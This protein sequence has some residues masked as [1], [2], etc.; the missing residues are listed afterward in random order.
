MTITD[1]GADNTVVDVTG[2]ALTIRNSTGIGQSAADS[3]NLSVDTLNVTTT[4]GNAFITEANGIALGVVNVMA[5]SLTFEAILGDITDTTGD[6]TAGALSL[7]ATESGKAIGTTGTPITVDA[8]G[9]L[10]A[11][12]TTSTGGI[13]IAEQSGSLA[14][15]TV[16]AGT[17]DI[18]LSAPSGFTN[19]TSALTG[20]N[21]KL[22]ASASGGS[23]GAT[24][25]ANDINVTLTGTLTAAASTGAGGIFITETNQ[26]D[27]ASLNAGSGA[28]ELITSAGDITDGGSGTVVTSGTFTANSAGAVTLD[29]TG[30]HNIATLGTSTSATTFTLDNN[31][32][33][34]T[35]AGNLT[36][37]NSAVTLNLGTGNYTHNTNIDINSGA[38]DITITTDSVVV[39]ANSGDNAFITS[40]TL[41]LN[42]ATTATAITLG[43]GNTAFDIEGTKSGEESFAIAGGVTGT[44]KIG[45]SDHNTTLTFDKNVSFGTA[46]V[47]LQA[48]SLVDGDGE[49]TAGTLYLDARNGSI[50]TS[51]NPMELDVTTLDATTTGGSAGGIFVLEADTLI[52]GNNF[53]VTTGAIDTDIEITT[54]KGNLTTATAVKTTGSGAAGAGTILLD[55]GGVLTIDDFVTTTGDGDIS[56]KSGATATIRTV[57]NVG[58]TVTANS[59]NVDGK[60]NL[61]VSVVNGDIQ[62]DTGKNDILLL[63]DETGANRRSRLISLN[64]Q[65]DNNKGD[66]IIQEESNDT[67]GSPADIQQIYGAGTSLTFPDGTTVA[68]GDDATLRRWDAIFTP[69]MNN[70]API[71]IVTDLKINTNALVGPVLITGDG[72]GGT[73][74]LGDV[75]FDMS[76]TFTGDQDLTISAVSI[77]SADNVVETHD[78]VTGLIHGVPI[79]LGATGASVDGV[80]SLGTL[81]LTTNGGIGT[82]T[83]SQ[84]TA[85]ELAIANMGTVVIPS[86]GGNDI[87]ISEESGTG[88]TIALNIG[89]KAV[90]VG[91]VTFSSTLRDLSITRINAGTNAVNLLASA[92]SI[93]DDADDV[94]AAG[95]EDIIGGTVTLTARDE[96]GGDDGTPAG[97]DGQEALEIASTSLNV[98]TT[99]TLATHQIVLR[100]TDGTTLTLLETFEDPITVISSSGDLIAADVH[101]GRTTPDSVTLTASTGAIQGTSGGAT[102][103]TGNAAILTAANGIGAT[104]TLTTAVSG[105][106]TFSNTVT[107]GINLSDS[108]GTSTTYAGTNSG[109]T[110][111]I[112]DSDKTGFTTGG[113]ITG[114]SGLLAIVADTVNI[115]HTINASTNNV[116]ISP[117]TLLTP[118]SLDGASTLDLEQAELTKITAGRIFIGEDVG[119]TIRA[120]VVTL[121]GTLDVDVG[122]QNLTIAGTA[123]NGGAKTLITTG[124]VTLNSSG[125]VNGNAAV[126]TDI[127]AGS[128]NITAVNGIGATQFQTDT[129]S[130]TA[131]NTSVTTGN[132]NISNAQS[133]NLTG[134]SVSNSNATGTIQ[135]DVTGATS[136]LTI[137][138]TVTGNSN[139]TLSADRHIIFAQGTGVTGISTP[140]ATVT[141][142]ANLDAALPSTTGAIQGNLNVATDVASAILF[143]NAA[144]GIGSTNAIETTATVGVGPINTNSGDVNVVNTGTVQMFGSNA[145]GG[146]YNFTVL[147][148]NNSLLVTSPVN[149]NTGTVTLT[150]DELSIGSTV[151]GT[152]VTL[153]AV[154]DLQPIEIGLT[155]KTDGTVLG[156]TDL[157][158]LNIKSSAGLT[159]GNATSDGGIT[160]VGA[161]TALKTDLTGG[162]LTLQQ[163]DANILV[164]ATLISPVDTTLI[165]ATSTKNGI[166]WGPAGQVSAAG[167]NVTLTAANR[168]IFGNGTAFTNVV[169][170]SLN[171]TASTGIGPTNALETAVAGKI[172]FSNTGSGNVQ[173]TD[174]GAAGTSYTGTNNNAPITLID[175]DATGIAVAAG[176]I[177]S[178]GN[179]VIT[180]R[181]NA[182]DIANLVNAGTSDV[183]LLPNSAIAGTIGGVGAFDLTQTELTTNITAGRIF[184]GKDSAGT[185]TGT[186]LSID[187]AVN[188]G[189]QELILTAGTDLTIKNTLSSTA[190]LTLEANNNIGFAQGVSVT[191]VSTTG[192]VNLTAD[193]DTSTAGAIT[194]NG[195]AATDVAADTLNASA[196]TGIGS[197]TPIETAVATL[198]LTNST[199]GAVR[200]DETDAVSVSGTN[201]NG[202][203]DVEVTGADQVLTVNGSNISAQSVIL[204][205]DQMTVTGTVT[206]TAG[207]TV[208]AENPT[209]QSIEIGVGAADSATVLGLLDTELMQFKGAGLTIG[210]GSHTQGITVV[211]AA[212]TSGLSSGTLTLQ[213]GSGNIAVNTTL[214][215]PIATTLTTASGGISFDPDGA[216]SAAGQTVTLTAT[217][218]SVTGDAATFTNVTAGT[219]NATAGGTI[220]T[221]TDALETAVSTVVASA[222]GANLNISNTGA[223]TATLTANSGDADFLNSGTF[224]TG[225][226]LSANSID[227]TGD[228]TVTIAHNMTTDGAANVGAITLTSTG[229]GTELQ[230]DPMT[231]ADIT[232]TTA[233]GNNLV[234]SSDKLFVDA[235]P[236]GS[237]GDG[238]VVFNISGGIPIDVGAAT[239]INLGDQ[240]PLG[241]F[242][243]DDAEM[244]A[245]VFAGSFAIGTGTTTVP[246][247]IDRATAFA[248]T[249]VTLT[250]TSTVNDADMGIALETSGTLTITASGAGTTNQLVTQ[251]GSLALFTGASDISD[252]GGLTL[253]DSTLT[254]QLDLTTVTG[255]LALDNLNADKQTVN[256]TLGGA[257][258][259]NNGNLNNLTAA[260]LN[261]LG[262][263]N[264]GSG[265]A[266]ETIVGTIGLTSAVTQIDNTNAAGLSVT[267]ST[268]T[269][270]LT[271]TNKSGDLTISN[272][273]SG[274]STITL[275]AD[276]HI[277]FAQPAATTGVTNVAG[278][279]ELTAD[280]DGNN[281][282]AVQGNANVATDV[283]AVFGLDVAAAEG[284]GD[285]NPLE[286][287][288]G[289][290][291]FTNTTSGDINLIDTNAGAVLGENRTAIAGSNTGG[292]DILFTKPVIEGRIWVFNAPGVA[293]GVDA[294][295][296]SVVLTADN[297]QIDADAFVEGNG[298][299]TLQPFDDTQAIQLGLGAINDNLNGA[300]GVNGFG[301]TNV[302]LANIKSS[303]G[304]VQIGNATSDGGITIVG[305]GSLSGLSATSSLKLQQD[306]GAITVNA[307]LTSP[308]A[309]TLTTANNSIGFGAAGAISAAGQSVTLSAAAGAITGDVANFTNV[310]GGSVTLTT[311]TGIGATNALQTASTG[312][313]AF[314]NSTSGV[315]QISDSGAAN[316]TFSGTNKSGVVNLADADATGLGIAAGGV[317]SGGANITLRANALDIANLVDATAA[318]V[319]LLPNTAS[320]AVAIGGAGT[321][322][323]LTQIELTTNTTAGRIFIGEDAAATVTAGIITLGSN[324]AVDV[325][326]QDLTISGASIVGG[327]NTLTSSGN[328]TLLSTGDIQG[329]AAATADVAGGTLTLTAATGLG[330][331]TQFQTSTTKLTADNTGA[332]ALNISNDQALNLDGGTTSSVTNT[333]TGPIQ[334]DVTGATNDLTI[335]QTVS[336]SSRI[337]LQADNNIVFAQATPITGV[338]TP[339]IVDLVADLDGKGTGAIQ[340]SAADALDVSASTLFA[341]AAQGIGTTATPLEATVIGLAFRNTTSGDV[342]LNP[343]DQASPPAIFG[344]NAGGGNIV[345]VYDNADTNVQ[346]FP[347]SAVATPWGLGN[348]GLNANTGSVTL[349]VDQ[350]RIDAPIAGAGVTIQPFEDLQAVE[351]GPLAVDGAA[352]LGIT[353]LEL[354]RISSSA[355]LTIGNAT[356][357]AG[358]TI[359]TGV[360]DAKGLTGGTFTL[361]QDTGSIIVNGTL[362]SPVATTLTTASGSISFGATGAVSA[363]GQ[364]VTLT[365][366]G[367]SIT[368]N[369]AILTNVTAG[370]LNATA[371]AG[372]IGT[373][374]DAL[375]TAASTIVASATGANLN[376]SNAANTTATLTANSGDIDFLNSGTFITGGAISA[377][378]IDITGN[379][380]VTIAH[381]LTTD[382]AATLG[383]IR[384][385]ST[386]VASQVQLDPMTAA[387]ITLTTANSN[388]L[389]L[390]APDLLIDNVPVGTD[391]DGVVIFAISG[392]VVLD[393]GAA[394]QINLGDEA[395]AGGF[396]LNDSEMD[397]L[398]FGGLL[399][400]GSGTTTAPIVL[401][402]KTAFAGPNLTLTTM[403]TV[404]DNNMGLAL[405]T[406]GTLTITASGAGTGGNQFATQVGM[407]MLTTGASN[408]S[409]SGGLTFLD[410]VVTGQLD[411]ATT[412]GALLLNNLTAAGQTVNFTLGGALTD[413]NVATTN[414]TA[415]TLNISGGQSVG[416]G[417]SLETTVST[418]G[419]TTATTEIDNTGGG[420][421]TITDSSLGG[422]LTLT[423]D[424]GISLNR[425]NAASQTVT[426]TPGGALT[427][428]NGVT[429]NVTAGTLIVLGNQAVTDLETTLGNLQLTTA[430]TSITD[431]GGVTLLDSTVTGQLDLTTTGGGLALD[432]LNATG[433]TVNITL[434][435]AL[436]DNNTGTVNV[437]A[438]TLNIGGGQNVGAGNSLETVVSTL[439]LVSAQTEIDNSGGLLTVTD[440]TLTGALTLTNTAGIALNRINAA[441]QTVTLTPGGALTDLNLATDNVTATTLIVLGN[442]AVTDIETTLT[443]LQL[444]TAATSII[445]TGGVTILDSTLTGQFDLTTVGGGLAL[446]N[447]TATGQTVNMIIGGAITDVNAGTNNVSATTLNASASGGIGSADALET[448]LTTLNITNATSGNIGILES[449]G[450]TV[451]N[452]DLT[453]ATAG[454]VTVSSTTGDIA[455]MN[456]AINGNGGLVTVNALGG[457]ITDADSGTTASVS[458]P[459]NVTL[460]ATGDIGAAGAGNLIDV[461]VGG[462]LTVAA[463]GSNIFVKSPLNNLT[464]AA[465]T[466]GAGA[467]TVVLQTLGTAN[468]ILPSG[469]VFT[470]TAS[471]IFDLD[472]A[473][474]TVD[475]QTSLVLGSLDAATAGGLVA[476][477]ENVTTSAA[478]GVVT[479]GNTLLDGLN[480]VTTG[481]G[482]VTFNGGVD[483]QTA[484]TDVD[485]AG[486]ITFANVLASTGGAAQNLTLESNANIDFDSS[487]GSGTGNA[488]GALLID[489]AAKI[490]A[491]STITA[492]SITQ[493]TGSDTTTLHGNVNATSGGVAIVNNN[494]ALDGLTITTPGQNVS[495]DGAIELQA[496]TGV[497][498]GIGAGNVLFNGV[499]NSQKGETNNLAIN[500][501][502]GNVTFP[503]NVGNNDRL[504]TFNVISAALTTLGTAGGGNE[505]FGVNTD[506]TVVTQ[507][508]NMVGGVGTV[509]SSGTGDAPNSIGTLSIQPGLNVSD[510]SLGGT[511]T[512]GVDTNLF[513]STSDFAAIGDD[514]LTLDFG[515]PM[516]T[517]FI[518]VDGTTMNTANNA[519]I[520]DPLTVRG[521]VRLTNFPEIQSPDGSFTVVGLA[522]IITGNINTLGADLIFQ[523]DVI[524]AEPNLT[525]Q[526]GGG[527]L[528]FQ[529][530]VSSE[531]SSAA[532]GASEENAITFDLGTTGNATFDGAIGELIEF[533]PPPLTPVVFASRMGAITINNAN[534]VTFGTA[535]D[536]TFTPDMAGLIINSATTVSFNVT[537]VTTFNNAVNINGPSTVTG[538]ALQINAGSAPVIL[539]ADVGAN[540]NVANLQV[541]TTGIATVGGTFD[542]PVLGDPS[543]AGVFDFLGSPTV[544]LATNTTFVDPVFLA[545]LVNGGANTFA[546]QSTVNHGSS[547]L[548]IN[549][550]EIDFNGGP[551]SVIGTGALTL[552]PDLAA[553]QVEVGVAADN[554]TGTGALDLSTADLAAL[555]DGHS[556]III[557]RADSTAGG[558][559]STSTFR[560]PVT[561]RSPDGGAFTLNGN[562]AITAN[563]GLQLIGEVNDTDNLAIQ[564]VS[565]PIAIDARNGLIQAGDLALLAN[566]GSGTLAIT[567]DGIL[568][569]TTLV[570]PANVIGTSNLA[571]IPPAGGELIFDN[572]PGV[573]HVRHNAFTNFEGHLILGGFTVVPPA[574][575]TVDLTP[576]S[577]EKDASIVAAQVTF[578]G[579]F[580]TNGPLT[581]LAE[582]IVINSNIRAGGPGAAGHFVTFVASTDPVVNPG[583]GNIVGPE[584]NNEITI[585]ASGGLLAAVGGVDNADN[586]ILDFGGGQLFVAVGSGEPDPDF[587]PSGD[588]DSQEFLA[589]DFQLLAG[590]EAGNNAISFESVV[591]AFDIRAE[592]Q[593]TGDLIL[594]DLSLFETELEI[595]GTIGRGVAM[596][597]SQCEELEGCAPFATEEALDAF[598]A[599]MDQRIAE[600]QRRLAAGEGDAA[601]IQALLDGYTSER[602]YFETEY[603]E[604]LQ[605]YLD[606]G[607]DFDDFEDDFGE[608]DFGDAENGTLPA[609]SLA[610]NAYQWMQ[611]LGQVMWSGDRV[612]PSEH[613]RY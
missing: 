118:V 508:L 394:T 590:L 466:T 160:V 288:T 101:A 99:G 589:E 245:L 123:I 217:G 352:S 115:A 461:N 188:V 598:V 20:A 455:L 433:Q 474:G 50:G 358:I 600:L 434:G 13:F 457:N 348:D 275:Q 584:G 136:D 606:E 580:V 92:G 296:G 540:I 532:V 563:D 321:G 191:G 5:N 120:G 317:S 25:A 313:I 392:N 219:L 489:T 451:Q 599:E 353:D 333:G 23:I 336:G 75:I 431:T 298:G 73:G 85:L 260:T 512:G 419:L 264:V 243:L 444:T 559:L 564:T 44:L 262:A 505:V 53:D 472:A 552:Q 351:I 495:L 152:G 214:T 328:I 294:N 108:G 129:A 247:I 558:V 64:G 126:V 386:G 212:N 69:G 417:N 209:A 297:M 299:V 592:L 7:T 77:S 477:R 192:T 481:G 292:G 218:G 43:T 587:S 207:I 432:N 542:T 234:L 331:S 605:S 473:T 42:P 81:T 251:V 162:T 150:A 244:D 573:G 295:T 279:I 380:T 436:T 403:S 361:Q 151:T 310:V 438:N 371:G 410:S 109:L 62:V 258:T 527:N 220:G 278:N 304:V 303:A 471:D 360:S 157:E 225:G 491:D 74:L 104:Q 196:A 329:N 282:G 242:R 14:L 437:T 450:F 55:A 199:S 168:R 480:I 596:D 145:G 189:S 568:S 524:I 357:D 48:G 607:D 367:G 307:T 141:L 127:K 35:V 112:I 54:T 105:L 4:S 525:V 522:Q 452:A 372:T 195:N 159:I 216:V 389:V 556:R 117:F 94:L 236:V 90:A 539:G 29:N 581:T 155:A 385:T 240:S 204:T 36:T 560:D 424:A 613:R 569:A 185:I 184:V 421:L 404:N 365:A 496:A 308:V 56:L 301:L 224:I 572:Q 78:F 16:N 384:L 486:T 531:A 594:F 176:G 541:S 131:S 349:T 89:T 577:G 171:L 314:T 423:S 562:T 517:T 96:I 49:T 555:A 187:S 137:S 290:T 239:E 237:D 71:E 500:A 186:T 208:L 135:I 250:T 41:H 211:G 553:T 574:T 91:N 215:S 235:A 395:P 58:I 443:N 65:L 268:L 291:R 80:N 375:E 166:F 440:S 347:G 306:T 9:T 378:S 142:N 543:G 95:D 597:I 479:T 269:G 148:T 449:D 585:Q 57:A 61:D 516:G 8:S 125:T 40:G 231:A 576:P 429:D 484:A 248:G 146:A 283:F 566:G 591:I 324:A 362:I 280:L 327:G 462:T 396:N 374:A 612:L 178:G 172:T 492:A 210:N 518:N 305:A 18:E 11:N 289:F 138:N 32:N 523:S 439:G 12:A 356:N 482:V 370:T 463:T 415:A 190:T 316:T 359:R 529:G 119:T 270:A 478:A 381:N 554:T 130:L 379:S 263:Q 68:I 206:S 253:L 139:I 332:S 132:I 300:A 376:I 604:Q 83:D 493:T 602:D 387:D 407:L 221:S 31:N 169:A 515:S 447:L 222:S 571:I 383:A 595:I 205:S 86:T 530:R 519:R 388:D 153:Q 446:N 533:P 341:D 261:I 106:I 467:D 256:I 501:G 430:A 246:I 180:L 565:G 550:A 510:V 102:D 100:E 97:T 284:I 601:R 458:N 514:W 582:N 197:A 202:A 343:R 354:A 475:V 494:I 490:E 319:Y 330:S 228:N 418:L 249:N 373:A 59:A 266:I 441:G 557:G 175:A 161:A 337:T 274:S 110:T 545:G 98:S 315:V 3:L 483:L 128:I 293:A 412:G 363:A 52:L 124:N 241:G 28:L 272:T 15:G 507:E 468:L 549:A 177:S 340:A 107:G 182:L 167:K 33:N 442:Q 181:A 609:K 144:E 398:V 502:T 422:P 561:L 254:G 143:A 460:M 402:R 46:T 265:N 271:L 345:A 487:V 170:G 17:G 67:A 579:N 499:V 485:A 103:V 227:I 51:A 121:P 19:A 154:D 203:F 174:S 229:T 6:V 488:L 465:I 93:N 312:N 390:S 544:V 509:T 393:E 526:T 426:L 350:I 593:N 608:D 255:G 364:T 27:I 114:G 406:A 583:T 122:A 309:T 400:I 611:E 82:R 427:D 273:V 87:N 497:D 39:A 420:I 454:T 513:I 570:L 38:G 411:F 355:G 586:I 456:D 506:F 259:D 285:A 408:I 413:N 22:T 276:R 369:A 76:A 60:N 79:N 116:Y 538:S 45:R 498:T 546:A 416:S 311:S 198:S 338:S 281:T 72:S 149:A 84:G 535:L 334:L 405:D 238:I 287:V 24:T 536:P 133:L 435:G 26:M 30:S 368:G 37:T 335:S 366:T 302:E 277:I 322:F 223:V 232:L 610:V 323:D 567:G 534:I 588:A 165:S 575:G 528:Q 230:L 401:D 156:I 382:G 344:S 551:N 286:T 158:L 547:G 425:I 2:A 233:N 377:N 201:S 325:G 213:Q 257:L 47:Q 476:L 342:V 134:A 464:V 391:A 193:R 399:G 10:T 428:A 448:T 194:G 267:A 548:V 414:V 252:T 397:A 318:N 66:T 339:N 88:G 470:N 445:D 111:S 34:L 226:A 346:I 320:T 520:K 147:G 537:G 459:G 603:R 469:L 409:D 511:E 200:V 113:T 140:S 63:Q 179:Q 70:D 21:L 503:N 183:H 163:D 173:I 164:N 1:T 578:D 326:T 504:G 453:G 521:L